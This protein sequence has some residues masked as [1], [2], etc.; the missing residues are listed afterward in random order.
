MGTN[1]FWHQLDGC[2]VKL[3]HNSVIV[4]AIDEN[5]PLANRTLLSPFVPYLPVVRPREYMAGIASDDSNDDFDGYLLS[6]ELDIIK[7]EY[8]NA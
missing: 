6:P 2:Y 5:N 8:D 4:A 3:H 7:Y 1:T